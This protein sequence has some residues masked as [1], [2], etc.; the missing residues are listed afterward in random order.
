MTNA[1]L[2]VRKLAFIESCI[3][4]LRRLAQP[5]KLRTDIKEERYV[6]HT[7]QIAIQAALDSA[8]HI[9]SSERLGE[10][11]TNRALFILYPGMLHASLK[12]TWR[13]VGLKTVF[14]ACA[15]RA[16]ATS[17]SPGR[18]RGFSCKRRGFCGAA[19]GPAVVPDAW[20]R[21]PRIW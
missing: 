18:P 19:F 17:I 3:S 12:I 14:Y 21:Q 10:P 13:A 7:L 20:W 1:E 5:E 9:V 16:A 2:V 4:E 6:T 8:S 15:A 11:T